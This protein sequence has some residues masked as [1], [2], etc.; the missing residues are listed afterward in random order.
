MHEL[1]TAPLFLAARPELA[2]I[3]SRLEL[4]EAHRFDAI[5][6]LEDIRRKDDS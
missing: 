2:R 3:D 5:I 6:A 1:A 4:R